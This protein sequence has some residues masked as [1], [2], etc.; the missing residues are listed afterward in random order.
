VQTNWFHGVSRAAAIVALATAG[1]AGPGDATASKGSWLAWS[2]PKAAAPT[3]VSDT[4][5][6]ASSF[7]SLWKREAKPGLPSAAAAPEVSKPI[8]PGAGPELLVATAHIH[9][10]AGRNDEAERYYQKALELDARHREALI[11]YAHL[12]DRQN[13]FAEATTIYERATT[14]YPSDPAPVNDL[15]LCLARRRMYQKSIAQLRRAVSLKP[16]NKL[17]RNNLATVLLE[18][19]DKQGALAELSAAH[20]EAVAHYNVGCLLHRK[21]QQAEALR[22]FQAALRI[23]PGMSQAHEWVARLERPTGPLAAAAGAPMA[24]TTIGRE[25][26]HFQVAPATDQAAVLASTA[27]PMPGDAPTYLAGQGTN[28]PRAAAGTPELTYPQPPHEAERLRGPAAPT[29]EQLDRAG[30]AGFSALPPVETEFYP[31]GRY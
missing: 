18:V 12:L 10:S 23:D 17:Y 8:P 24:P 16:G 26:Q 25:R 19:G 22:E 1:C 14:A 20:G 7:T 6:S 13:R 29:P 15:G 11:G 2:K 28:Q 3:A 5:P 27:A 9:E 4:V 21:G 31:R 30:P